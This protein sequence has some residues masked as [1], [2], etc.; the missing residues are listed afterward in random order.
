MSSEP[1]DHHNLTEVENA[2]GEKQENHSVDDECEKQQQQ[3]QPNITA[4]GEDHKLQI[5]S[6]P[7]DEEL[8]AATND[9]KQQEFEEQHTLPI[10]DQEKEGEDE[11]QEVAHLEKNEQAEPEEPKKD[12]EPEETV[13]A[14]Q[15]DDVDDPKQI[16]Q[17]EENFEQIDEQI[18]EKIE[19]SK[20]LESPEEL[21]SQPEETKLIDNNVDQSPAKTTMEDIVSSELN[22]MKVEEDRTPQNNENEHV[23]APSQKQTIE[24]STPKSRIRPPSTILRKP[25]PS[26][27][28]RPATTPNSRNPPVSPRPPSMR[29][30]SRMTRE[31][32]DLRKSTSTKSID[33][34][35]RFTPKVNA[36]FANVKSKV[37]SVTNHKPGG[38]NVEIFSEKR[39]YKVQSKV[40]SLEKAN[41]TPGGGNVRIEN[42]KLDFS[43]AAPKVGSKTNY[44]PPK[45][46]VKILHQK[47]NWKAESKVGSKDNIHHKPG[48]GNVQIFDEKIRFISRDSSRN[49]STADISSL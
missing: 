8:E 49:H 42:R 12:P 25:T 45:S 24:T 47:L 15:S 27:T 1:I 43:Y 14:S 16:Q 18:E 33:N 19:D 2:D 3:Q 4:N 28:A 23:E 9:E 41:H 35:G 38:G 46:D 5:E 40:G 36:K 11:E 17:L 31:S 7:I 32:S 20:D 6:S 39:E 30:T 21:E 10:N 22:A 13:E 48:G 34:A 44:V 29:P 26:S 37:G